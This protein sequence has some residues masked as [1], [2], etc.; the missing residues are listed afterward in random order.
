MTVSLCLSVWSP[1]Y[2]KELSYDGTVS[3][4]HILHSPVVYAE[5]SCGS[6]WNQNWAPQV[7]CALAEDPSIYVAK[8]Y[9]I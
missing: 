8:E 6:M 2:T 7:N 5:A 1:I 4:S 9:S 3:R